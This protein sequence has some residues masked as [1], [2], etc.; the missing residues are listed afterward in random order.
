MTASR[1]PKGV[2]TVSMPMEPVTRRD[3][4]SPYKTF[5]SR[6]FRRKLTNFHARSRDGVEPA[7]RK[8]LVA[9]EQPIDRVVLFDVAAFQLQKYHAAVELDFL[10]EDRVHQRGIGR[11]DVQLLRLCGFEEVSGREIVVEPE[12]GRR[13]R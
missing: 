1:L 13:A 11:E 2:S 12:L 8:A 9:G 4:L 6:S 5:L 10:V 7:G 3:I